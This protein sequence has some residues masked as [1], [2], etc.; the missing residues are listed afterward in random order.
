MLAIHSLL[1][2]CAEMDLDPSDTDKGDKENSEVKKKHSLKIN[3]VFSHPNPF[4]WSGYIPSENV[5]G[6]ILKTKAGGASAWQ[7]HRS[8]VRFA[9]DPGHPVENGGKL[10]A[11]EQGGPEVHVCQVRKRNGQ[12]FQGFHGTSSS[13]VSFLISVAAS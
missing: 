7:R 8:D 1:N 9:G 10:S 11:E 13:C 5:A 2:R 12:I 4:L 6:L 3:G